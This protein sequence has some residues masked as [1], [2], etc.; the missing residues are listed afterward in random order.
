MRQDRRQIFFLVH[1]LDL[2]AGW[3]VLFSAQCL[4]KIISECCEGDRAHFDLSLAKEV[5][6]VGSVGL[7]VYVL[8]EFIETYEIYCSM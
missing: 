4:R 1:F 6:C 7:K 3:F 5:Y 8:I 2:G